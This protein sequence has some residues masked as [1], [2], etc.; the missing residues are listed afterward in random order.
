MID[1]QCVIVCLQLPM[2]GCL[3]TGDW[4]T[5]DWLTCAW[6][7]NAWMTGD[8]LTSDRLTGYWMTADRLTGNWKTGW[9]VTGWLVDQ[10]LDDWWLVTMTG[11]WM[12]GAW[13]PVISGQTFWS[14]NHTRK[15]ATH[16]S[17][18]R[19]YSMVGCFPMN[20]TVIWQFR[21]DNLIFSYFFFIF[22]SARV[23]LLYQSISICFQINYY[24]QN[25]ST[26]WNEKNILSNLKYYPTVLNMFA[27]VMH[28]VHATS[29][30]I[31]QGKTINKF[32]KS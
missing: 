15:D 10:W 29:E 32:K 20:R 27:V 8:W 25:R 12:T 6:L 17:Y 2:A 5:G 24:S 14:V 26:T 31:W 4:L 28:D 7:T 3:V 16:G 30:N 1:I 18:Y 22:V 23:Y 11:D 21:N 19:Q 13:W 9:L